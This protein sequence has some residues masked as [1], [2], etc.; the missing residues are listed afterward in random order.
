M[1]KETKVKP[2][3]WYT[4]KVQ[5]IRERSVSEKL[6]TEMLRE[7]GEE[8][9][10]L[11]PT[12]GVATIKDGKKVLKEQILYPG[13]IFIETSSIDKIDHLVK[14]TNGAT[15]ILR[16]NKGTP[17]T[18]KQS[19]VDRMLGEKEANSIA[20]LSD[21]FVPGEKVEVKNGPFA[22]FKGTVSSVDNDKEKVKVEVLIFG[23]ST[24][25]DLTLSD[26]VKYDG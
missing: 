10:F 24:M 16:D 2:K 19:E 23:R 3:N 11:I 13:Y 20:V 7:F 22:S 9:N 25:V 12:H 8:V 4:I 1:I 18:L 14:T 5:N 15:N 17:I 6:K 21:K 26:I